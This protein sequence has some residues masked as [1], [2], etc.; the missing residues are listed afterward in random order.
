MF[1]RYKIQN[2]SDKRQQRGGSA[3]C[4]TGWGDVAGQGRR[5]W[6]VWK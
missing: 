5:E 3:Q 4:R 6:T 1:A 2:V